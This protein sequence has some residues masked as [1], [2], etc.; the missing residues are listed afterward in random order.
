VIL[1]CGFADC[2]NDIHVRLVLKNNSMIIAYSNN[3][4]I[5]F[6]TSR[7]VRLTTVDLHAEKPDTRPESRFLPTPPAFDAPVRGVPVGICHPVWHEKT[8]MAWLPE[9]EKN[10]KISLFVL[11]QFTNVT[12]GRTDAQTPH[13]DIG[14]AYASHRAAKTKNTVIKLVRAYII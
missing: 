14:C 7:L 12:D 13:A 3:A 8:R 11:A 4:A 2:E 5:I 6:H 1:L 9:S 10:S